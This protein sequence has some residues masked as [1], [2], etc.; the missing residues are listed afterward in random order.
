MLPNI[1]KILAVL[2]TWSHPAGSRLATSNK[3]FRYFSD[4]GN[5]TV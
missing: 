3:C 5:F 4:D 1:F 2:T